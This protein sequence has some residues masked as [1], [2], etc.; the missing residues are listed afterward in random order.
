[1]WVAMPFA[2]VVPGSYFPSEEFRVWPG[3]GLTSF[4]L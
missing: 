3:S 2:V 4:S 1:M